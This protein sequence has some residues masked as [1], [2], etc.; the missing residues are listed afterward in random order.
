MNCSNDGPEVET[1]INDAI[2]WPLRLTSRHGCW[3]SKVRA[4]GIMRKCILELKDRVARKK[5]NEPRT[6]LRPRKND[7]NEK[8]SRIILSQEEK[9]KAESLIISAIQSS[10]FQKEIETLVK[11]GIFTPNAMKELRT[12]NSKIKSLSP[13]LD[14]NNILR[15][16]GRYGKADYLSFNMRYPIILPGSKDESIKSLIVHYHEMNK[17]CSRTQTFSLL[18]LRYFILGGKTSIGSVINR[19]AS[20]QMLWKNPPVQR[21]G[22][23][24]EDRITIA[25]PFEVSGLDIFGHFNIRHGGRGTHKRW[26]LLATCFVTRAIFLLPLRDMTS[27]TV[28][29]AL[30]KMNS[31][32]PSL[33]KVHSDNGSNFCGADREIREAV[34]KWDK[35]DFA[36]KL[37]KKKELTGN[38]DP[39]LVEV[40]GECGSVLLALRKS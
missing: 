25:A 22:D 35:N 18:R 27:G 40:L 33:K 30:V 24:P 37:S 19:C 26:V 21:L 28:I 2:P 23:L 8:K 5:N 9:Q 7:G 4:V 13:F 32:F 39:P 31:Q 12:N 10:H 17:H 16:G 15:A 20:C 14:S 34:E 29:N 36:F 6:R 1:E 11:L 3:M 38:L